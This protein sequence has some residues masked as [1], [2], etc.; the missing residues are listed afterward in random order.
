MWCIFQL[1]DL[2]GM[3]E[4]LRGSNPLAERINIPANPKHYWKYRI[5]IPLE[6]LIREKEF[7]DQLRSMIEA[8]SR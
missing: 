2:L 6:N 7:T 5:H 8:S 1:Q 3:S 4:H